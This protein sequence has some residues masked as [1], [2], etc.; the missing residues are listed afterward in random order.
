[1]KRIKI[2][3]KVVPARPANTLAERFARRLESGPASITWRNRHT[4]ATSADIVIS[5]EQAEVVPQEVAE[6]IIYRVREVGGRGNYRHYYNWS[7]VQLSLKI[8][9]KKMPNDEYNEPQE[10]SSIVLNRHNLGL[11]NFIRKALFT[12]A[13]P[14]IP[15]L[16]R[17]LGISFY[18]FHI[19]EIA[20]HHYN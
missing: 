14:Q 9:V 3:T 7:R 8:A 16:L 4:W 19:V 11:D 18:L 1:M 17:R 13:G 5:R 6:Q 10:I 15:S 2:V 12:P 20:I